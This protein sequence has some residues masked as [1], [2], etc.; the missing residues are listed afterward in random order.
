MCVC[1]HFAGNTRSPRCAVLQLPSQTL[2]PLC[3]KTYGRDSRSCTAPSLDLF[4]SMH[5]ARP[6]RARA[7]AAESAVPN[8]LCLDFEIVS[9]SAGQK[10]CAARLRPVSSDV[11]RLRSKLQSLMLSST[12]G[13]I[14]IWPQFSMEQVFDARVKQAFYQMWFAF[15]ECL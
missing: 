9:G 10:R 14:P 12:V 4:H 7:I 15:A 6:V 5:A 1:V 8:R 11:W 2:R 3:R 13:I